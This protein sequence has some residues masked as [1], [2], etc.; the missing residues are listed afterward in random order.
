MV[1][2]VAVVRMMQVAV[3]QIVHMVAVRHGLMSTA[4]AVDM[5]GV[6]T[7]AGVIR[8]AS[9]RVGVAYFEDMLVDVAVVRRMQV[10]VVQIVDVAVVQNRGVAAACAVRMIMIFVDGVAHS[11]EFPFGFAGDSL[12]C[13]NALNTRSTIC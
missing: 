3:H 11:S 6:M 8:S 4:R 9:R 5:T 7:G 1:V 12:A 10:A 13:A 2:A